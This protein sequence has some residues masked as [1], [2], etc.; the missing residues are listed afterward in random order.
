MPSGILVKNFN[1]QKI[2]PF[3]ILEAIRSRLDKSDAASFDNLEKVIEQLGDET[4]K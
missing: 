3:G 2:K 4:A 1:L